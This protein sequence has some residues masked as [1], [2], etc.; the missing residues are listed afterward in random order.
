MNTIEKNNTLF[1]AVKAIINNARQV[2]YRSNNSILLHT[3]WEIGKLIVEEEQAGQV[4]ANYGKATLKNLS[5]QLI[6]EFGKGYDERNL[7]NMRAFYIA[8]PIWYAVRTELSWTHYRIISRIEDPS[9]RLQYVEYSIA[10]NW[11]TRT[12]QR[13]IKTLYLN[14][15]L[16]LPEAKGLPCLLNL[17]KTLIFLNF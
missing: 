4:K 17:L 9:Y 3:Y 15:Q 10:S 5:N 12:L 8:F 11:D 6:L 14:R 2:A 1:T 7:N 13:N 16:K